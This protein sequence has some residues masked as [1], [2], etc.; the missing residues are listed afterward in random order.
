MC[1]R[2]RRFFILIQGV[3]KL[4]VREQDD[5]SINHKVYFLEMSS[6]L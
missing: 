3:L 5:N 4:V 2:V 1:L 6:F